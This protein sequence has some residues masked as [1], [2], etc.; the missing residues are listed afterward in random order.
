[1]YEKKLVALHQLQAELGD[2]LD[3]DLQT[4]LMAGI[5]DIRNQL[6]VAQRHCHDIMRSD[7]DK[8]ALEE[9]DAEQVNV[10]IQHQL[11]GFHLNLLFS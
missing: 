2:V 10:D 5:A 9:K 11:K 3:E 8:E 4:D 7:A 1:M 6:Y